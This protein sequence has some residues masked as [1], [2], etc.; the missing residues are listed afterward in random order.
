VKIEYSFTH[1]DFKAIWKYIRGYKRMSIQ[2]AH[3]LYVAAPVICLSLFL[4]GRFSGQIWMQTEGGVLLFASLVSIPVHVAYD[5]WLFSNW[6]KNNF[7]LNQENERYRLIANDE[8]II[9][10]KSDSIQTTLAWSVITNF[11]QNEA[12]TFLYISRDNYIYFPT[13]AM[14]ADQRVELDAL[15]ARHVT[16]RTS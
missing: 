4:L 11:V 6:L 7:L 14:N 13:K 5:M 10:A 1:E 2:N 3:V 16:R 15:V 9:A 12:V 8:E